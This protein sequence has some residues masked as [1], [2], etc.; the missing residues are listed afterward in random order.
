MPQT[1]E[2]ALKSSAKKHGL[3]VEELVSK[4]VSEKFCSQCK[5][6]V[7]RDHYGVDNSRFDKLATKCFTCVRAVGPNKNKGRVSTFKGRKHTAESNAKNAAKQK[8]LLAEGLRKP[9]MEG[10]KHT[11]E[12]RQKISTILREHG[13]KGERCHSYKDGKS[14]E[15]KGQRFSKEYKQWRYDVYTRDKFICQHCGYDKGGNLNAHH[16]KPYSDFPEL[17]LEVS[18]GITLC[19]PC[20]EAAHFKA[21][22][23]RNI[24]KQKRAAKI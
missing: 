22:S 4:L 16:I 12:T 15:R 10:R 24:R 6:W 13:A 18:N 9:P 7:S 19:K 5:T 20:H 11:L 1:K 17:R 21:D 8:A 3:S 23:T 14:L 2:G